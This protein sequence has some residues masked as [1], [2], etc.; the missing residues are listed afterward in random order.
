MFRLM[1]NV[2]LILGI[3]FFF[4]AMLFALS[5]LTIIYR[6]WLKPLRQSQERTVQVAPETARTARALAFELMQN[7]CLNGE[8]RDI[9]QEAKE[10]CF[11]IVRPGTESSVIY[12]GSGGEV[13]IQ[14]SRAGFLETL[15]HLH[16]NHGFWHDFRA[17]KCL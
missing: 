13:K 15:V 8:L 3:A 14:T 7:H 16:V 1:R 9:K 5:S 12:S 17:L 2:H 6:P 10:I 11:S 4:Y